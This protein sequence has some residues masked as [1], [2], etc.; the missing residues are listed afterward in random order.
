[1][2]L[3]FSS[4]MLCGNGYSKQPLYGS[5]DCLRYA[6]PLDFLSFYAG[7]VRMLTPVRLIP[8]VAIPIERGVN[9]TAMKIASR[10]KWNRSCHP[11]KQRSHLPKCKP[12]W[13]RMSFL[14]LITKDSPFG[15]IAKNEPL[16]DFAI[17]PSETMAI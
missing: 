2:T 6:L 9:T 12:A 11:V 8:K 17:P 1:M 3:H 7:A 4:F 15:L 10:Q 16:S 5:T 13:S 14:S